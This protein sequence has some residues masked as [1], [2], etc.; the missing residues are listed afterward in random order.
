MPNLIIIT[1]T[2]GSGKSTALKAFEDLGYLAIDNFP[3]RLLI[4]FLK[5]VKES[6]STDKVALVMDLRDR[7]FLPEFKTVLPQIH[8]LGYFWELI[9]LDARTDVIISRFNLTRRLHP[10]LREKEVGLEEVI[11]REKELLADIRE[12]ATLFIDTSNYNVHQLRN[13]IFTRYQTRTDLKN[14]VLHFISFGYKYGIPPEADYVFDARILPNPYFN[15]EL[16]PLNG[17]NPLIKQY[18]LNYDITKTFLNFLTE[19]L[20]WLIPVYAKSNKRYL[21]L[22]IGCT[23]GRHRSVALIEF[24]VENLKKSLFEVEFIVSHR[25]IKKDV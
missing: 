24:L 10:L 1:G 12:L 2:S 25:D 23:G 16:K 21:T 19:F 4:S 9:F 7:Y 17:E 22:A 15:P 14:L 6:L 8:K 5:E 18:L 13:E 3:T 11:E 20:N